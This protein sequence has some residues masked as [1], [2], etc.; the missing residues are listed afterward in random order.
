MVLLCHVLFSDN[1]ICM[2]G[3]CCLTLDMLGV[4]VWPTPNVPTIV[5][6][7]SVFGPCFVMH[8][9]VSFP[10]L[11]IILMRKKELVALITFLSS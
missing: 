10:S 4:K 1:L 7:G 9:L 6:G 2:L 3:D 11:A 5:C 8:Y